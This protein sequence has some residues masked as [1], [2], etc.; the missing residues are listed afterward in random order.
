MTSRIR[1]NQIR[2]TSNPDDTLDA[3][4][5]SGI[6]S[7]AIDHLEFL[8]GILSQIKKII[9]GSDIGNWHDDIEVVASSLKDLAENGLSVIEHPA[10]RQLIHFID[11]GPAEQFASGAYKTVSGDNLAFPTSII[12]WESSTQS[13]KIVEKNITWSGAVPSIVEWKI[14]DTDGIT[15]LAT[16]T[17]VIEYTDAIFEK[18]RTRAIT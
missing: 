13:Q 4:S 16:V 18:N 1:L 15:T 5:I 7:N 2:K 8:N 6:E 14:Y 11:D 9:H 12:W 17:D 10:I 3:A